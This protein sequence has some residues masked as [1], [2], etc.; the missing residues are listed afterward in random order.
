METKRKREEEIEITSKKVK[1]KFGHFQRG[2]FLIDILNQFHGKNNLFEYQ[3]LHSTLILCQNYTQ[4]NGIDLFI[5]MIE[6]TCHFHLGNFRKCRNMME[7]ISNIEITSYEIPSYD[8]E[9]ALKV[10]ELFLLKE[11]HFRANHLP[12]RIVRAHGILSPISIMFRNYLS[13]NVNF[14]NE[15]QKLSIFPKLIIFEPG[16]YDSDFDL[17]EF[18]GFETESFGAQYFVENARQEDE[19]EEEDDLDYK[20]ELFY[21]S[22]ESDSSSDSEEDFTSDTDEEIERISIPEENFYCLKDDVNKIQG[23]M[24]LKK[25]ELENYS[26]HLLSEHQ[27]KIIPFDLEQLKWLI[28]IF[29]PIFRR[30]LKL[31][32]RDEIIRYALKCDGGMFFHLQDMDYENVDYFIIAYKQNK[33]IIKQLNQ[34]KFL[35]IV[36]EIGR[37]HCKKCTKLENLNFKFE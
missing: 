18:F 23:D 29:P 16:I 5:Q 20:E 13:F 3:S 2:E 31:Q 6:A 27:F 8:D 11:I 36:E 24:I 33:N 37:I 34:T 35:S 22:E 30:M 32:E 25:F 10:A 21:E 17:E 26:I 4:E 14:S 28:D 9:F 19:R 15:F 7:E 12:S 1:N